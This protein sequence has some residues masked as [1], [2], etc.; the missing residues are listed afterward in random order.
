MTQPNDQQ[1]QFEL[2]AQQAREKVA[3]EKQAQEKARQEALAKAK[4]EEARQQARLEMFRKM[5]RRYQQELVRP[6]L[7]AFANAQKLR[8]TGPDVDVPAGEAQPCATSVLTL[9]RPKGPA[10]AVQFAL[11][12][13]P[14]SMFSGETVKATLSGREDRGD[15]KLQKLWNTYVSGAA[16]L[17]EKDRSFP[18]AEFEKQFPH[19]A[20]DAWLREQLAALSA[21]VAEV[22][23][24]SGS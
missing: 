5:F 15:N 3:R 12:L 24:R 16:R 8:F 14:S 11:R 7:I 6:M 9:Q 4:A 20:A 17:F 13:A 19:A 1:R 18:A 23:A 2:A 21:T 10:I 22:L